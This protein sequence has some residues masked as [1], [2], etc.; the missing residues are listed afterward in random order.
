[1]PTLEGGHAHW[2]TLVLKFWNLYVPESECQKA[3]QPSWRWNGVTGRLAEE[4]ISVSEVEKTCAARS[5]EI[6]YLEA[7]V[8][9]F[10]MGCTFSD[11]DVMK[12]G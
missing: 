11:G 9:I 3:I 10:D 12:A 8:S 4:L 7:N 2:M 6:Q 1:M 5:F